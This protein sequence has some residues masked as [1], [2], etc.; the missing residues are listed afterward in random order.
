MIDDQIIQILTQINAA[1][2]HQTEIQAACNLIKEAGMFDSLPHFQYQARDGSEEKKYLYLI[3]RQ[4]DSGAYHGPD[5]K[6]KVYIGADPL[7]IAEARRL[8]HNY[9][10]YQSLRAKEIELS[11]WI[12]YKKLELKRLE[13]SVGQLLA[14]SKKW[15]C[16]RI[17]SPQFAHA[18]E[19][20]LHPTPNP[21]GAKPGAALALAGQNGVSRGVK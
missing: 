8:A 18:E 19:N 15:P 6:R 9:D 16:T 4:S 5:G 13:E 11:H 14:A 1:T 17:P 2:D 7:K 20:P 3:F 12:G 10:L 21:I